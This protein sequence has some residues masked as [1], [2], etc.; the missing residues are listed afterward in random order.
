MSKKSN[1]GPA[2]KRSG[3]S[4]SRAKRPTSRSRRPTT[5]RSALQEDR[6]RLG[7]R[8]EITRG[9]DW[10]VGASPPRVG[11]TVAPPII[12]GR[13]LH[14]LLNK[15]ALE[16]QVTRQYVQ[17]IHES[18]AEMKE[19]VPST[20]ELRG[21][22]KAKKEKKRETVD[23]F[24]K[25][26]AAQGVGGSSGLELTEEEQQRIANGEDPADVLQGY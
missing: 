13:Q 8:P 10:G 21:Q 9:D 24:L 12:D 3:G 26:R 5:E 19:D 11:E 1:R 2:P 16:T 18:I 4:S 23:A 22:M 20:D 25:R 15:I 7:L 17:W 14:R 6:A